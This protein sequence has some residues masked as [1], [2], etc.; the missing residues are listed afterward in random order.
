MSGENLV[1][2]NNGQIAVVR[3]EMQAILCERPGFIC[4]DIGHY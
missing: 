2:A 3:V 4:T 1:L